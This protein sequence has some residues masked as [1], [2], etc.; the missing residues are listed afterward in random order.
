MRKHRG[1]YGGT[2]Q[3]RRAILDATLA[4]FTEVGYLDTTMEDIRRRSGASNGSIYHHFKGKEQLAAA[5]YLQGIVDYQGGLKNELNRCTGAREGL[6]AL[7]RYHL[8]WVRDHSD[9]ARFLFRMRH[10]DFMALAERPIADANRE[11]VAV[12]KGFFQRH[13]AAGTLRHLPPELYMSIVLGPC[14]E[15]ARHWLLEKRNVDLD[16][17][18]EELGEAAWQSLRARRRR[19][20]ESHH[21][22]AY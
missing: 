12:M 7:V 4:C 15:L 9:W 18:A 10:A 5:L 3:R 14:Q 22:P 1:Q 19:R 8:F 16:R 13:V 11:L 6:A 21:G 17:A 2:E 20:T